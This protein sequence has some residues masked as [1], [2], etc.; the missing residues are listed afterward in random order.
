MTSAIPL[1]GQTW[2]VCGGR[3]YADRATFNNAM[4]DLTEMKGCPRRIIHGDYRGADALADEWGRRMALEVLPVPADW[5]KHGPAAGP[6]RN[7]AML[8]HKPDLVI[9]FPGG[10]GTADMV[11]KARAAGIDVAEIREAQHD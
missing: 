8:E 2:L 9:A 4:G 3:D 11:R 6:I 5:K 1:N 10:G 7:A